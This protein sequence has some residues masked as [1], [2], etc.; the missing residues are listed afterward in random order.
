MRFGKVC[1]LLTTIVFMAYYFYGLRA[2]LVAGVSCLSSVAAEYL[3]FTAMKK[4]YDWTD[5]SPIMSGLLLALLMPASVPYTVMAFSAAFM[6]IVCKHAFGGNQ[7]LIFPPVCVAY[8]FTAFCF[9]SEIILYPA[10]AP[11]GSL[12]LSNT[13]T[14]TL[15]RSYTYYLDTGAASTFSLLD[16]IW[17]KITGPMGASAILIILICAIALYFFRDI[18]SAAF[19]SGF[20]ANVLIN[21]LFPIGERGWDAVLSSFVAGSFLFVLVFLAC[22]PR[23]VPKRLFSQLL[24]GVLFAAGSYLIRQ[25]TNIENSAVIALPLLCIF[26]D[27]L[28]RLTDALERLIKFI[29]KWLKIAV[30]AAARQTVKLFDRFCEFVSDKIV[31][32]Q[33]KSK[34]KK[35]AADNEKETPAETGGEGETGS[36]NAAK[37]ESGK[38]PETETETESGKEPET[39]TETES[40]PQPERDAEAKIDSDG[41]SGKEADEE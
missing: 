8:I 35:A 18:P 3:C 33:A 41:Q 39:E 24:Y 38:E 10:P 5:V 37:T 9:P 15:T 2:V 28:D 12:S 30:A 29:R 27:E 40:E 7:N 26:K 11:F 1:A 19:F 13:V 36:D 22:D 25:F 4:K 17:G 23:F 20:G 14:E 34:A 6:A 16:T 31:E 21:V 32:A